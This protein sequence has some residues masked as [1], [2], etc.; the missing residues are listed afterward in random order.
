MATATTTV[1]VMIRMMAMILLI[2][3]E[4]HFELFAHFV[5]STSGRSHPRSGEGLQGLGLWFRMQP[6][7]RGRLGLVRTLTLGKAWLETL[8]G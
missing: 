3:N 6:G 2:V 7:L 8:F 1:T 5:S 4:I